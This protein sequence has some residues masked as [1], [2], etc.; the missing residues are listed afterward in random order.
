VLDWGSDST[1][2]GTKNDWEVNHW[3][4]ITIT[5]D[6]VANSLAIY[7]GDENN[8]PILDASMVWSD[9]VVGLHTENN[10]MNS[11]GRVDAQVDGNIDDFRYYSTQ[12]NLT[13]I[14]EDY[15]FSSSIT[16]PSLSARYRFENDLSDRSSCCW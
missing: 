14:T 3:Y 7:W 10:I 12:R 15:L 16:D 4:F 5:W 6:E 8:E 9:S 13:D 11:I 2:Q 1:I